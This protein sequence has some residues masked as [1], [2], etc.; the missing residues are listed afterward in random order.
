MSSDAIDTPSGARWHTS[1]AGAAAAGF[2]AV[3]MLVAGVGYLGVPEEQRPF[4]P[5]H[6]VMSSV[7]DGAVALPALLW[8]LALQG[9]AGLGVVSA[10]SRRVAP[11]G[12]DLRRWATLIGL[13]GFG[14]GTIAALAAIERLPLLVELY[15]ETD[16]GERGVVG[17][18]WPPLMEPGGLVYCGAVGLWVLWTVLESLRGGTGLRTVALIGLVLA[19]AL[20]VAAVGAASGSASLWGSMT[21]V[22]TF[23]GVV[24]FALWAQLL[25]RDEP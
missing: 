5:L 16:V 11:E 13:L 8:V 1:V 24:W 6:E 19:V 22:A 10:I 12:R 2:V 20:L 25:V 9:L 21:A 15:G 3:L 17:A 7:A 23:A 18:S 14:G 4:R